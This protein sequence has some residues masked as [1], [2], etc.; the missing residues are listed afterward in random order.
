MSDTNPRLHGVRPRSTVEVE[1][2]VR[3]RDEGEDHTLRFCSEQSRDGIA[4]TAPSFRAAIDQAASDALLFVA[5][6]YPTS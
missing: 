6:A 1:V 5:R 4:D 3:L 2:V